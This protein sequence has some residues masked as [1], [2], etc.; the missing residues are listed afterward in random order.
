MTRASLPRSVCVC[1]PQCK[2]FEHGPTNT[3][4]LHMVLLAF[5]GA[6]ITFAAEDEHGQRVRANLSLADPESTA[7]V[8]WERISIPPRMSHGAERLRSE[9][10]TLRQVFALASKQKADLVFFSSATALG[11]LVLKLLLLVRRPRFRVL[12]MLHNVLGS[13][14]TVTRKRFSRFRGLPAVF[15][16][17]QPSGLRF[18]ALGESIFRHL[19]AIQPRAARHFDVLDL[20]HEWVASGPGHNSA[21]EPVRFGFLGVSQGKG[22]QTFARVVAGVRAAEPSAQFSLV[23]HLNSTE[24][25]TLYRKITED[26]ECAPLSDEEYRRR[27]LALTY[28]VWTADPEHYGL[29]ASATFLDTLS[30]V[31]PCIYLR[32]PYIDSYAA[33]MGDIG[34]GCSTVQEM[35]GQIISLIRSFPVER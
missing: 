9:F 18:I 13:L 23:G 3:A 10:R 16:L 8:C 22:F 21:S 15:S 33:R 6:T 30:M 5:P 7:R 12:A 11:L 24:D 25:C 4:I 1:E 32:N 20:P 14:E 34:Y 31:K 28:A 29:V 19:Q 26:A 17:P 35:Q 27:G 2:G